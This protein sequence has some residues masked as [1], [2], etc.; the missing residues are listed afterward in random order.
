MFVHVHVHRWYIDLLTVNCAA[1]IVCSCSNKH[2]IK[3]R[4]TE[5]V[6]RTTS[7]VELR[8]R[9]VTNYKVQES[10]KSCCVQHDHEISR[11]VWNRQF[12]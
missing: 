9:F 7:E 1:V 11:L 2:F 10:W 12:N 4:V 8:I 3:L 5:S 6:R